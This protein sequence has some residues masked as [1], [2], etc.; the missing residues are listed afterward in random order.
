MKTRILLLVRGLSLFTVITSL[1]AQGTA[2]TYQGRLNDGANP[3]NG[4][5]DLTF[6]LFSVSNGV[7]Q[8]GATLTNTPAAVSN[9]L[10]TVTLDFGNQFP[11]AARWL[12]IGVRTNGAANFF[13][14]TPRQSLTPAPYAITAGTVISGGLASGTYG[15]AVT[16]NNAANQFTGS[17]GGNGAS[18]TNVN[19]AKLGGLSVSNFWQTGG[20]SGTSSNNFLGTTD[21]ESFEVRVGNTRVLRLENLGYFFDPTIN[22]GAPNVIAGSPANRVVNSFGATISGGGATNYD[23][24]NSTNIVN[25]DFG[26]VGG[27]GNNTAG[28]ESTVSGGFGN[29][30]WDGGNA[31]G[32]G[33]NN[34][35]N[36][37]GLAAIGGGDHNAAGINDVGVYMVIGGGLQNTNVSTAGAIGGGY[38]NYAS[39]LCSTV[40]GGFSNSASADFSFA[41]GHRANARHVGSFVW[42]D[43][44]DAPYVSTGTNQFLI[45]AGGGVG[46]GTTA[47]E[48]PLHVAEGSAGAVTANANSIAVFEKSGNAYVSLLGPATSETGILFGD[49]NNAQ[50]G[51]II[52]N[53]SSARSGLEFRTGTNVPQMTILASGNVGIGTVSPSRELEVWNSGDTEIGIRSTDSGG[54]LWTLQ[55]SGTN[56]SATLDASFQIID[57]TLNLS[58]FYIGTNGFVGIGTTSPTNKLHVNGGV[59]ATVFVTTSDR[60]AKENFEPVSASEVLDKVAALPITR[61]TF[62]EMP[63][64]KHL[65]PM[66]QDFHAA[67]GLGAGNTGIATVDESGVALAAIQGLNEKV[68]VRSQKSEVRIQTLEAENA[69]LKQ[70]LE[71]LEKIIRNQKSN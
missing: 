25:G 54:H 10:F 45:R 2:F 29:F 15:N 57:R 50:D 32:G 14:L 18:V 9:G 24:Y 3:A 42:A 22:I 34:Y 59:S 62:K 11:G 31:I 63:G 61:W 67:F 1:H 27:G 20:N 71:A 4:N 36:G 39:N 8:V 53:S 64:Q 55:S 70:R 51:G 69:E 6:A 7:G 37:A 12:E 38:L 66:A 35:A 49:P 44:I 26:T 30:T 40:P 65:G 43:S 13:T 28:S 33:F 19:A 52:F 23:S 41:A 46:I 16:L 5:Y 48:A 47:P 68:E 58:R 17:F 56:G 21:S 60:N